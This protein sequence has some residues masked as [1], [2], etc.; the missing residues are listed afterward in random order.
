MVPGSDDRGDPAQIAEITRLC[1]ELP[2]AVC[3]VASRFRDNPVRRLEDVV[4]RLTDQSARLRELDDGERSVTAVFAASCATLSESHQAMLSLL[5]LHPGPRVDAYAAGA[6]AGI[7]PA[8]A[9]D[10]LDD[11]IRSGMLERHSHNAYRL[12]DMLRDHLRSP[13]GG[14]ISSAEASAGRRRLYDYVLHTAAAANTRANENRYRLPLDPPTT[15]VIS[16]QF[17]DALSTKLWMD[18]EVDNFLPFVVDMNARE[19]HNEC[20][21][22]AH[23]LREYFYA[24]KQWELMASCSAIA[25]DSATRVG[26][27]QATGVTLNGLGLAH[28][29]LNKPEEAMRLYTRARAEFLAADDVYGEN[30]VVANQSWLAY[31]SEDFE[32]ALGLS[33]TAW[34][35]YLRHDQKFNAAIALDLIARCK[36]RLGMWKESEERFLQALE[37]F[38]E[39]DFRDGDIAQLLS[40]LGRVQL[41]RGRTEAAT[42]TFY[43]AI[44]RARFGK[45][46]R[47]EAV[48]FEGISEAAAASGNLVESN[49]HRAAAI[50]LFEEVGAM[51]DAVRLRVKAVTT[52]GPEPKPAVSATPRVNV[53]PRRLTLLSVNTEWSSGN[54]GLSTLNREL[55]AALAARGADVYCSVPGATEDERAHAESLGVHLVHPPPALGPPVSALSRPP[56]F[57]DGVV[58]DV[59]IGHGRQTGSPPCGSW[60]TTSATPNSC[61]SAT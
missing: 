59:V 31:D 24:S 19:H 41:V 36:F 46:P 17:P 47:E 27:H 55:C 61:T 9:E 5:A 60:R 13:S 44:Q 1:Y 38:V 50:A 25:L 18:L 56:R 51:D 3:I 10:V 30:N 26:S 28:S 52:M 2:L 15:A 40:H 58:P 8:L 16:P 57:P 49:A 4:A 14:F 39:L 42:E 34:A 12:H 32:V 43:E 53:S 21:Q 37:S 23:H 35:F 45:A 54:G 29:Q 48:A 7:S 33:K 22:F 6:L 20:W 11:L